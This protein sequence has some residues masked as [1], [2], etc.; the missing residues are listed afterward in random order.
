MAMA[1]DI[2]DKYCTTVVDFW[3]MRPRKFLAS[4]STNPDRYLTQPQFLLACMGL[5]TILIG[6]TF[7]FYRELRKD[8]L[9][10]L[11][12]LELQADAKVLAGRQATLV[13]FVVVFNTITLRIISRLW[14]VRG[15]TF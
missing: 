15:T 4:H 2:V 14:P 3:V 7:S 9:G 12:A 11:P 6:S 10:M 13:L 8:V 1:F 5:L